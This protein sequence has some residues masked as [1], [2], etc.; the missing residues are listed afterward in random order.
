MT[1]RTLSPTVAYALVA[2]VIGLALFASGTPSPLYSTYRELWG[3]SPVVLTL[4]YA[5]YAFGVLA[6]LL[7]A[8]R[9]SD[10]IGRRPV[11]L[12]AL[13]HADG[14]V[15]AVHVRRLGRLAVRRARH[16]G[17]RH[18]PRARRRQRRAARPAPAP[19][20]GR[21]RPDQRRRQ[22]RRHGPRRARLRRRWSSSRPRRASCPTSSCSCSSRSPSSARCSCP[23]R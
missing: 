14:D 17:A 8:G 22:R 4:I 16:P 5:T 19:R 21:R 13:A 10:E 3:F 11:L 9:I 18:R 20:P 12:T 15:G 6:A 7:L 2:S 1:N 23:S